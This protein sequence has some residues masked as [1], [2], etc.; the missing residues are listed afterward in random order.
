MRR[1]AVFLAVALALVWSACGTSDE[2][3]VGLTTTSAASSTTVSPYAEFLATVEGGVFI[4]E[5]RDAEALVIG[6][7]FT[8]L[9]SDFDLV[10]AALALCEMSDK[11][12]DV[13]AVAEASEVIDRFD[14]NMPAHESAVERI[15]GIG[16]P[17]ACSVGLP[18]VGLPFDA[19]IPPRPQ[20]GITPPLGDVDALMQGFLD[21][22]DGQM[23]IK[24]I[25][26]ERRRLAPV[27][28]ETLTDIELLRL[29]RGFCSTSAEL[30]DASSKEF[31]LHQESMG[32]TG[33]ADDEMFTLVIEASDAV[34]AIVGS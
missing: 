21:T 10:V 13:T 23:F 15:L 30:G 14:W 28:T 16:R 4:G 25:R 1:T 9:M 7:V 22:L 27:F 2:A 17:T 20:N 29:A 8:E 11:T 5:I 31:R 33:S 24:T 26:D 6:Q 3:G 19:V 34:C 18:P 32:W 12:D